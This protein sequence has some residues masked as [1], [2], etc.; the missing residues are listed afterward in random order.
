M[1]LQ[2]LQRNWNIYGETD[3]LWS[4][5][6]ASGKQG[7]KWDTTAFF[8]TGVREIAE[9][10]ESLERLGVQLQRQ[11][12]L[13]FGCGVGRLTQALGGH[14]NN[15]VG[16][17][18]APSMIAQAGALNRLGERCQYFL[19]DAPNL[20]IFNKDSFDFIYSK[21]VLQ[22]MTQTYVIGY[23]NEFLRVLATQGVLVFQ[24]PSEYH[25]EREH[26]TT[27]QAV[28]RMAPR[29]L[30][31]TYRKLRNKPIMEM[32]PIP[33][34]QIIQVLESAGARVVHVADDPHDGRWTSLLY[35]AY[36]I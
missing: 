20:K 28:A 35:F 26:R 31:D 16:V 29:K 5:L 12:A 17:D 30:L 33:R 3:P 25:P 19:N 11:R 8:E 14:F 4:I 13:D 24:L 7:G 10:M 23:L 9:V 2:E 1:K 15:V 34:D 6:S 36:K 27:K 18:I 21:Y 22:H 32:H